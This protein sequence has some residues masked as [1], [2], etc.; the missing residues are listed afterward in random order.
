MKSP[1][2][3]GKPPEQPEG[4]KEEFER[5]RQQRRKDFGLE[6]GKEPT[7]EEAEKIEKS[8]DKL[9][10]DLDKFNTKDYDLEIQDEWYWAELE[11]QVGKD[12][13]LAKANLE[14]LLDTLEMY[15]ENP[16]K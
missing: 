9:V 7:P 10:K 6:E 12:R 2:Q 13:E 15:A 4:Q 14:R 11:A 1:E 8:I 5:L 16:K 3:M